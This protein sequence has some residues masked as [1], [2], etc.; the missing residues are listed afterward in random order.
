MNA[1][2]LR[3][4]QTPLKERYREDPASALL[5]PS[6]RACPLFSQRCWE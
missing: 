3:S 6:C 1:D 5:T 4:M 2:E